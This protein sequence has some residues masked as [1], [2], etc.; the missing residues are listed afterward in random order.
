[1]TRLKKHLTQS[2][3]IY[4]HTWQ[5]HDVVFWDNRCVMHSRDSWHRDYLR[6]MHR[7]QAGGS[8]PF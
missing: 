2:H 1:M 8:R 4:T 5:R 3:M 7:S 6:E